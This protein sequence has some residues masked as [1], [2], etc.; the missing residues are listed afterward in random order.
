MQG[1]SQAGTGVLSIL[2]PTLL[3]RR[4]RMGP[5]EWH[6]IAN[7]R[8]DQFDAHE[9]ARNAGRSQIDVLKLSV[10]SITPFKGSHLWSSTYG[11]AHC[12]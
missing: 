5:C 3:S 8:Q 1:R 4:G 11:V 6:D 9:H 12:L 7:S 10:L 2:R